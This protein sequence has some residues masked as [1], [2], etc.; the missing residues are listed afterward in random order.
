MPPVQL[1]PGAIPWGAWRQRTLL[2]EGVNLKDTSLP[3]GLMST[4]RSQMKQDEHPYVL[5]F[6]ERKSWSPTNYFLSGVFDHGWYE[7]HLKCWWLC[8]GFCKIQVPEVPL[9]SF[10]FTFSL[11]TRMVLGLLKWLKETRF[12]NKKNKKHK[13]MNFAFNVGTW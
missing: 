10:R 7:F 4:F 3:F 12:Y 5:L 6:Q 8:F 11:V 2:L 1:F 13:D 9:F